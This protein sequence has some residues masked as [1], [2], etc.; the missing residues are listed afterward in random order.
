VPVSDRARESLCA[1]RLGIGPYRCGGA[2]SAGDAD[3]DAEARPAVP[4]GRATNGCARASL[5][6]QRLEGSMHSMRLCAWV[7]V[8][9][10]VCVSV[11]LC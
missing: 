8:C 4:D 6:V 9:V 10:N 5:T 3:G 2:Q 11:R 1:Q 7:W